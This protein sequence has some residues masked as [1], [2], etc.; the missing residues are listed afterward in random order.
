MKAVV[1]VLE[2]IAALIAIFNSIGGSELKTDETPLK[3]Y[4]GVTK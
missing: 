4:S 1:M 3:F 2:A